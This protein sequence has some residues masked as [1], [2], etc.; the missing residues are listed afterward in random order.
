MKIEKL[1]NDSL[2]KSKQVINDT[3]DNDDFK[4]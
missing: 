4:E 1:I 2:D 3:L